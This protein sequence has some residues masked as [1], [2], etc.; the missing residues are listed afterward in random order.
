MRDSLYKVTRSV[1]SFMNFT[2]PSPNRALQPPGWRLPGQ[3][4]EPSW[5]TRRAVGA[6]T[7]VHLLIPTEGS[8]PV[9]TQPR[10]SA[11]GPSP[12]YTSRVFSIIAIVFEV[13]SVILL[14]PAL[15]FS[16]KSNRFCCV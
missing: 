14:M 15:L 3:A 9:S 16:P 13:P 11:A 1:F 5:P 7:T 10:Y 6:Q 4:Q 12:L 2:L 8:T